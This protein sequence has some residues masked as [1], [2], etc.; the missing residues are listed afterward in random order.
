ML[1]RADWFPLFS[2]VGFISL[3]GTS[4]RREGGGSGEVVNIKDCKTSLKK[5]YIYIY[6]YISSFFYEKIDDNNYISVNKKR[7]KKGQRNL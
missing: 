2:V 3:K 6:I 7:K 5:K 4:C 1:S